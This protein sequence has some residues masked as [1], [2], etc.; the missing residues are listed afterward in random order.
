MRVETRGRFLRLARR[1]E[2]G[3]FFCG[4][5]EEPSPCAETEEPSPRLPPPRVSPHSS[6]R[7]R[8]L[9]ALRLG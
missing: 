8:I 2:R 5:T 3:R 6:A 9:P 1:Q 4:D 7:R